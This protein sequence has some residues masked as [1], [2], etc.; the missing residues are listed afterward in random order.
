[1]SFQPFLFSSCLWKI[2]YQIS[3]SVQLPWKILLHYLTKY[4]NELT[5]TNYQTSLDMQLISCNLFSIYRGPYRRKLSGPLMPILIAI[6]SCQNN[7]PHNNTEKTFAHFGSSLF[8]QSETHFLSISG[9][10]MTLRRDI[11]S[12]IHQFGMASSRRLKFQLNKK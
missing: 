12:S 3:L 10:F 1:M 7:L 9:Q 5:S 8:L 6:S 4:H 11:G 2:N